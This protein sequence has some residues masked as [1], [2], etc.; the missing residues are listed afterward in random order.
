[1]DWLQTVIG[2]LI[3]GGAIALPSYWIFNRIVDDIK[4]NTESIVKCNEDNRKELKEAVKKLDDHILFA[5]T[6]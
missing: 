6:H 4:G 5:A 1:M 2:G 3:G